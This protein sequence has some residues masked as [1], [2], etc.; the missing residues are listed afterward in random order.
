M[1]SQF[2]LYNSNKIL[3]A[4]LFLLEKIFLT[5]ANLSLLL[6]YR[7]FLKFLKFD[8]INR[9]LMVNIT[10]RNIQIYTLEI[11]GSEKL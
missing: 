11:N 5:R 10:E 1:I 4:K 8:F 6:V 7:S 2:S 9:N 3:A